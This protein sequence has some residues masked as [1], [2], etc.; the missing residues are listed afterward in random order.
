MRPGDRLVCA[1]L[2]PLGTGTIFKE[3]PLHVTI[4]P[5]FRLDIPTDQLSTD[6]RKVWRG[7]RPFNVEMGAENVRFGHQKGKLVTLVKLSSPLVEVEKRLRSY[8][9]Q[10]NAWLVDES[11]RARRDFRPHVT[12]QGAGRLPEG[13]VFRGDRLYI[14]EQLG[15]EK[16]ITGHVTLEPKG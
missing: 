7:V 4:V 13:E 14:V 11:T 3:W 15:H 16:A 6:L 12:V 1:L 2:Q 10:Q 8:L 5:W 9:H